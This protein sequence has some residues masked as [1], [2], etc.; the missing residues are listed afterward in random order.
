MFE[1]RKLKLSYSAVP[2]VVCSRERG[3]QRQ[4]SRCPKMHGQ[5]FP[6]SVS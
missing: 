1:S 4:M 3:S 5:D 6:K 2:E